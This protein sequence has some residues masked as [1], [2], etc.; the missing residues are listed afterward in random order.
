MSSD[1]LVTIPFDG[2]Y[3]L[4][5]ISNADILRKETFKNIA[6]TNI[7]LFCNAAKNSTAAYSYTNE[8]SLIDFRDIIYSEILS[9]PENSVVKINM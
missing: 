1:L 5:Y 9:L 6:Q 3:K 8:K 7:D 4:F 2:G